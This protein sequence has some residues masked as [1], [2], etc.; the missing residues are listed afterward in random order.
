MKAV[1]FVV[2]CL[3]LAVVVA[4]DFARGA[5]PAAF[6][7]ELVACEEKAPA[8]ASGW[9]VYVPCCEDVARRYARDAGACARPDDGGAS[10]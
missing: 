1:A 3:V 4:C 9:A 10:W 7:A 8:G 6:A 5:R 2:G